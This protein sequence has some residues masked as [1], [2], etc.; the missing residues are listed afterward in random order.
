ME[1]ENSPPYPE[2]SM[3]DLEEETMN[4]EDTTPVVTL[5]FA[6]SSNKLNDPTMAPGSTQYVQNIV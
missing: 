5:Q 4:F 1:E 3:I 6:M 2:D